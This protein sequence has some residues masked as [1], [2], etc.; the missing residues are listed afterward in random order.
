MTGC[1]PCLAILT[2]AARTGAVRTGAVERGIVKT[3]RTGNGVVSFDG[4]SI[5]TICF[6][7][8]SSAPEHTLDKREV[9]R[10]KSSPAHQ[11]LRYGRN[12]FLPETPSVPDTQCPGNATVQEVAS[13]RFLIRTASTLSMKVRSFSRSNPSFSFSEGMLKT[14]ISVNRSQPGFA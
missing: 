8:G 14:R 12:L 6:R 10:F 2:G 1:C 5:Q 9:G 7:A 3:I 11:S 4:G 13:R